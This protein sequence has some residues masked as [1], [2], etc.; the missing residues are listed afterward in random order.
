MPH[1]LV[2]SRHSQ[3]LRYFQLTGG[4]YEERE[5]QSG[6]CAIWLTDLEIGLGIWQGEFEDIPGHWLRWCDQDGTWLL[7]DTE[8]ERQEKE[9]ARQAKEQSQTQLLQAAHNLLATGM[10]LEQVIK[11]LALSE[12]QVQQL[13]T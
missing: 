3:Q 5:L 2:Y 11:L 13:Q 4:V 6:N 1:Y 9:Q 8:Q 10:P 12:K 7:T